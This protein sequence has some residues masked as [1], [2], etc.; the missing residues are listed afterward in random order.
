MKN[1][2]FYFLHI[3]FDMVPFRSYDRVFSVPSLNF[4]GQEHRWKLSEFLQKGYLRTR[5]SLL[6]DLA[7]AAQLIF[8]TARNRAVGDF[9]SFS[10][11]TRAL[12]NGVILLIDMI[13]GVPS[14]IAN[15]LDH[16]IREE[17]SR[18]LVAELSIC[19]VCKGFSFTIL[20]LNDEK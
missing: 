12:V 2:E 1:W 20:A 3:F 11:S 14:L 4:P 6:N 15:D 8:M 17:R 13:V 18:F 10:K 9:L 19:G 16:K 7:L 5:E